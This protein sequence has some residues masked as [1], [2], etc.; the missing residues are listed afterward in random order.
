MASSPV[1]IGPRPSC[2]MQYESRDDAFGIIGRTK[3][4][5]GV[6]QHYWA[7]VCISRT[8]TLEQK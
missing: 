2:V 5:G 7:L 4:I 8:R 6:L 1:M 3:Q